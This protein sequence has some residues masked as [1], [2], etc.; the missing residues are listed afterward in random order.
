MIPAVAIFLT[1]GSIS[2]YTFHLLGRL[3]QVADSESSESDSKVMS[4]GQL[5]DREI[6][7]STS[8]LVTLAI[9]LVAYCTCLA[10]SIVLGDTFTSLASSAGLKARVISEM[11][12]LVFSVNVFNSILVIFVS[13]TIP[14]GIMT[15]RR[16]NVAAISLLG[17]YPLCTLKSLAAL[18][19]ISVI[20]NIGLLM[21]AGVMTLRALPG[22]A[23]SA[24]SAA[25]NYLSTLPIGLHPSFGVI[26]LKGPKS[27]FVLSSMA[28][29]AFLI[30]MAAPEFYQTLENKSVKRF[31]ILSATGFAGV[32]LL[33]AY[34][35]AVGFLTFGGACKGM[36]LNN[37]STLDL[38]ATLCRFLMGVSLLG[39]YGILGNIMKGAFFQLLQKKKE[40][41]ESVRMNSTRMLVGSIT[42]LALLLEDAGFVVSL[43]GATFGT[44]F[45]YII[46]SLLFLKSTARRVGNGS[47]SATTSLKIERMWN[48]FLI[49]LGAFLT[50]AGVS[51][52]VINSFFPH[53]L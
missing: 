28:A 5:W 17:I 32:V 47:M 50:A 38:G 18:K 3:V 34:M 30:H 20:G 53:M 2:A 6:G 33:S 9:F 37:Y 39:S 36:I 52:T 40:V 48:R 51:M 1:L 23:Y 26:G 43:S 19:P 49:A 27:V 8:Y 44:A 24:A 16:A 7:E 4:L 42:A 21:T 13:S 35:M 25:T 46:P 29:T 12:V 10:Y 14:Q 22:G 15:S 31:G 41:T 45:I 11:H